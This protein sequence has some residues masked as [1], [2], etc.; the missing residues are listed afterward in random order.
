MA[1]ED[2]RIDCKYRIGTIKPRL[3]LIKKDGCRIKLDAI[4]KNVSFSLTEGNVYYIDAD[5]ADYSQTV[6]DDNRW[7]FANQLTFRVNEIKYNTFFEELRDICTNDYFYVITDMENNSWLINA[8]TY[9]DVTYTYTFTNNDEND[10]VS[11]VVTNHTNYPLLLNLSDLSDA[12]P[13]IQKE[14][15]YNYG[16]PIQLYISS[17]RDN[18][19]KEVDFLKDTFTFTQT[20]DGELVDRTLT[21]SIPLDE[22]FSFAYNLLEYDDNI[23]RIKFTTTNDNVILCG[24]K[25]RPTHTIDTSEDVGN[26]NLI[27]F[28]FNQVGNYCYNSEDTVMFKH[29]RW[30][31]VKLLENGEGVYEELV[32]Y[33]GFNYNSQQ[34]KVFTEREAPIQCKVT[35]STFDK[36]TYCI[37]IKTNAYKMELSLLELEGTINASGVCFDREYIKTKEDGFYAALNVRLYCTEDDWLD[38]VYHDQIVYVEIKDGEIVGVYIEDEDGK[39]SRWKRFDINEDYYCEANEYGTY[40]KW[41]KEYEEV[42]YDG[43]KTWEMNGNYRKG[44]LYKLSIRDCESNI[45]A[46]FYRWITLPIDEGWFCVEEDNGTFSK[47][48][49]KVR[50]KSNDQGKTW[51]YDTDDFGNPIFER[52]ELYQS[53]L[54]ECEDDDWEI[55]YHPEWENFDLIDGYVIKGYYRLLGV[56]DD[57]V[58][59]GRLVKRERNQYG[60]VVDTVSQSKVNKTTLDL[61]KYGEEFNFTAAHAAVAYGKYS[62]PTF[63]DDRMK[64]IYDNCYYGFFDYSGYNKY[65]I[66]NG[67]INRQSELSDINYT[68]IPFSEISDTKKF[69]KNLANG[70]S[71]DSDT[72]EDVKEFDIIDLKCGEFSSPKHL[73][74]KCEDFWKVIHY[75]TTKYSASTYFSTQLTETKYITN[76]N[77]YKYIWDSE[78]LEHIGRISDSVGTHYWTDHN[79]NHYL[80]DYKIDIENDTITKTNISSN[81]YK[82]FKFN[83]TNFTLLGNDVCNVSDDGTITVINTLN[84]EVVDDVYPK[85]VLFVVQHGFFSNEKDLD[86]TKSLGHYGHGILI[87]E[88]NI[89][90]A[91]IFIPT[92]NGDNGIESDM[93]W[94]GDYLFLADTY[95]ITPTYL[96]YPNEFRDE[97][98][99]Y[100]YINIFRIEDLKRIAYSTYNLLTNEYRYWKSEPYLYKWENGNTIREVRQLYINERATD[101]YRDGFAIQEINTE[102]LMKFK[103]DRINTSSTYLSSGTTLSILVV[104]DS[105]AY[106][107][108][109]GIKPSNVTLN[110][111]DN[112]AMIFGELSVH[113]DTNYKKIINVPLNNT[114]RNDSNTLKFLKEYNPSEIEFASYIQDISFIDQV[115][116]VSSI[117]KIRINSEMVTTYPKRIESNLN[118]GGVVELSNHVPQNA[119]D[120][121][122]TIFKNIVI[123][124]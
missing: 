18:E 113:N 50:Q 103:F 92:V 98:D 74:E 91:D 55:P 40:T 102:P 9:S 78:T 47:Y 121:L 5:S 17:I 39:I 23:Y 93:V 1:I 118:Y 107:L 97:F 41:Y 115:T 119:V 96:P 19:W 6:T 106:M 30:E 44:D 53:N 114:I 100:G 11:V 104:N 61:R 66:K 48:Y 24:N 72:G 45:D 31:F 82:N 65:N 7:A 112:T 71:Y 43:G 25:Y 33:D 109:K 14:C 62:Q 79:G 57:D 63:L 52:G 77:L 56:V 42:S 36:E 37:T 81:Y 87:R 88:D 20:Y 51:V 22:K 16:K 95:I 49:K 15:G 124:P 12:T 38:G 123:V 69:Y 83:G 80:N 29:Y 13:I 105:R 10:S 75:N 3:Y 111:S 70:C 60:N 73:R 54:T 120:N 86:L 64:K 59:F 94:Q 46:P 84:R 28:T 117:R 99:G 21:F 26:P 76:N 68:V 90:Y 32:S 27:T 2:Y 34:E 58:C 8:E 85:G 89:I 35:E 67:T 122:R 116:Q 101:E 108:K 110:E 4:H